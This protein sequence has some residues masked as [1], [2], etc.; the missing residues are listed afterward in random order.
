MAPLKPFCRWDAE[1]ELTPTSV[2]EILMGLA[3]QV[4]TKPNHIIPYL[5]IPYNTVPYNTIP[6]LAI[7]VFHTWGYPNLH[8]NPFPQFKLN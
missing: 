3:S 1:G 8:L 6:W 5:V 2:D 7:Q 4:H